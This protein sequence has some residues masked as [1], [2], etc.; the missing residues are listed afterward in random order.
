MVLFGLSRLAYDTFDR[1]GQRLIDGQLLNVVL[2]LMLTT[3]IL[4]PVLTSR[5]A[6]RMLSSISETAVRSL[7]H[8]SSHHS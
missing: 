2:V 5:F 1:A 4:G 6:P 3:A 8:G 7:N